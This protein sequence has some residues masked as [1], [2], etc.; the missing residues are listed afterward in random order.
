[1]QKVEKSEE[2]S[3]EVKDGAVSLPSITV[4]DGREGRKQEIKYCIVSLGYISFTHTPSIIYPK[5][6]EK[7]SKI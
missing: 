5:Y 1:M 7:N 6:L 3:A 2:H 4:G